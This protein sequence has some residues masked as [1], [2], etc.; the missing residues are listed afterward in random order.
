MSDYN[1]YLE[2]INVSKK[3]VADDLQKFFPKF[4]KGYLSAVCRP[5]EYGIML[6]PM[7]ESYLAHM[8][9]DG[10]GLDQAPKK[11]KPKPKRTK[12]NQLTIRLD[13]ALAAEVKQAMAEDGIEYTQAFF[14]QA[15]TAYLEKRKDDETAHEM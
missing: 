1:K 7:A 13:D 6:T 5:E 4:I 10:P 9:G 12:K 2:A 3:D 14:E 8:Y 11:R 15:L